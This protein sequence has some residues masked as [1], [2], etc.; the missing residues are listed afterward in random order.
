VNGLLVRVEVGVPEG[1]A[2]RERRGGGSGRWSSGGRA[3][4]TWG[5]WSGR[6]PCSASH[7]RRQLRA[8]RATG[9]IARARRVVVATA[10]STRLRVL[11]AMPLM[12][13]PRAAVGLLLRVHA[14]WIRSTRR[15]P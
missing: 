5:R 7:R 9:A 3:F 2:L 11:D 12:R 4:M 13:A 8:S 14:G 15:G 1:L 6:V 10:A